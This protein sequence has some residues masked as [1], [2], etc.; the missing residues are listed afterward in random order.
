MQRSIRMLFECDL[1]GLAWSMVDGRMVNKVS[2]SDF[3]C[4][5]G[6]REEEVYVG[7]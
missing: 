6:G 4:C 7:T 2:K 3:C 1:V 5:R